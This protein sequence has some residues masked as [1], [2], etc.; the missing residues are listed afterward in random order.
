MRKAE[1]RNIIER[2]IHEIEEEDIGISL[3]TTFYQ[4]ESELDF[5]SDEDK[6]RVRV[7][8]RKLSEDSAHHK[9]ALEKI[10]LR[11]EEQYREK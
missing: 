6:K 5:F 8:L 11:L 1:I 4:D 10:I 2:L 7:I 3:F 9:K